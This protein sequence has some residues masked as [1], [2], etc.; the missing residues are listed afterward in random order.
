MIDSLLQELENYKNP[1]RAKHSQRFFKTGRGEY[2][3][4]D[5][6][7]GIKTPILRS[8]AKKYSNLTLAE[9]KK[10]L[11]SPVHDQRFLGLAILINQYKKADSKLRKS[12]YRF[13][14]KNIHAVN[15][16][17]L[18]DISCHHIIGNYL[19]NKPKTLLYDYSKSKDLWLRRISI[20]STFAFIRTDQFP[21]TLTISHALLNDNHD[22]IHKAVGWML[23]E[24][25]KKNQLIL[26]KFL[27]KYVKKMPRTM[28]RYSIEKFDEPKR[29]YYLK[30]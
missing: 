1:L 23:R 13:Y 28:L 29:Q 21:P 22:L 16:W 6:F 15:N 20:I 18:V 11:D 3:E 8:L 10:L 14:L 19:L 17:D 7:W 4:G 27:D 26:E 30:N 5:I 9:I 25:G 2:G 12:I 24:V